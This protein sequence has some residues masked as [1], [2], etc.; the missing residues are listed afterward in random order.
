MQKLS[1]SLF[2]FPVNHTTWNI[3]QQ[4][5][6]N[7]VSAFCWQ[8]LTCMDDQKIKVLFLIKRKPLKKKYKLQLLGKPK[9]RRA[10]KG[11][12][13]RALPPYKVFF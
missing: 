4:K 12:E 7:T 2:H 11:S 10:P 5:T 8:N 3:S 6:Y 1:L 13:C 9:G